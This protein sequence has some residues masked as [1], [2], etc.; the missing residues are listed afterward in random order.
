MIIGIAVSQK[1]EAI[2]T[3]DG[4]LRRFAEKHILAGTRA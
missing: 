2:Y 4:P 1:A 3:E